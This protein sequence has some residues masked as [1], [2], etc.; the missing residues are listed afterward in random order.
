MAKRKPSH[1]ATEYAEK[2]VAGEIIAGKLVRQACERH[3]KDL[4][5]GKMR[6][7]YFDEEAADHAI[8]FF[9]FL[10]H[11]KGEWAG[12][13]FEL[14][15]WQKFIVGSLFG[16]KNKDGTRRFR[17]AYLQ[18]ARKNGK[19]TLIAGIGLYLFVADGEAG[20]EVY[21]AATKR[22]QAKIVW[23]EAANM[24]NKSPALRKRIEVKRSTS[25]MYILEANSKFEALG[26]DADNMDGLNVHGA[27]VDELHAHRTRAVW[28]VL[29]TATGARR[30]P[31][32]IAITTAGFDQNGICYE[33]YEYCTK[34]LNNTIEDDTY[35]AYIATIDEGDDWTDPKVWAKANPNLGISVKLDDLERKCKKAKEV[36][37]A[38]N[39]FLT[40]HLNV[41]TQ[42]AD[43]WLDL[44]L[45]DENAGIVKEEDL[46]GRV[47]Y[48]GLDLSSVSDITAWVMAFPDEKDR[49]KVEFLCRFWCPEARLYDSK[50]KYQ[51]QY[52][53]WAK[54]GFLK[55]TPGDAVDYEFIKADILKDAKKFRL[56]D[57]NVDRL[58]QAH[59]LSME[60]ADEGLIVVGMGQGFTSMAAPVQEFERRLLARKLK[61]GGNPVL[62]WMA[63]NVAIKIDP[64][65]NK[66]PDKANSQGK[67]DGIVAA[68]MAL[69][70]VMR[71]ENKPSVYETRGVRTV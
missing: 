51:D 56:I 35:F 55:V 14:Q 49:E 6:G 39:N 23:T 44:R 50:N 69:D 65:G 47:C 40:K 9:R 5:T 18:I 8:E 43:R 57:M 70:R 38:Q 52:Q 15:P 17:T 25:N 41:W 67:I 4:K 68:I 58:F 13:S 31:L 11:S 48:G 27:L 45:W 21:T 30:Q 1:P 36:P 60:L 12:C 26:A 34:I 19:S 10:K 2:V 62:R 64:A 32:L 53:A 16:W 37:A 20:A 63:D 71:H 54:Q 3:L 42:Q 66:K 28:D 46:V 61:H 29:E 59:Q 7:L 24:V 22:D 33:Q